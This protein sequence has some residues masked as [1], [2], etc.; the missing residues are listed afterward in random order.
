MQMKYKD[1]VLKIAS[2][3]PSI[4][5]VFSLIVFYGRKALNMGDVPFPE[6]FQP[7]LSIW[8][9]LL[10]Y[11][12]FV[13][14]AL[15]VGFVLHVVIF[16]KS[17]NKGQKVFWIVTLWVLNALAIPVYYMKFF[18]SPPQLRDHESFDN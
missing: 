18:N 14:M 9:S 11:S 4:I 15:M 10:L 2:F 8:L 6:A 17:L 16:N 1:W 13:V 12:I 5:V 7:I 3:A